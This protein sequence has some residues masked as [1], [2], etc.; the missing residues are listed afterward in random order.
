MQSEIIEAAT[1]A[2][3]ISLAVF[4]H[5]FIVNRHI[6]YIHWRSQAWTKA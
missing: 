3:L 4:Q 1:A 2:I 6:E 5:S